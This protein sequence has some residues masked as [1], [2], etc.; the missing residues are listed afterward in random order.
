MIKGKG[1]GRRGV[2]KGVNLI[3]V[4]CMDISQWNPFIQLLIPNK[5]NKISKITLSLQYV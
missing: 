4:H 2:I 1:L 3:G 5:N